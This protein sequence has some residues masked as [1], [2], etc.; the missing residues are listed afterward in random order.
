VAVFAESNTGEPGA[1]I[2]RMPGS[3]GGRR[4]RV[5]TRGYLAGGLPCGSS[6]STADVHGRSGGCVGEYRRSGG[7]PLRAERRVLKIQTTLYQEICQPTWDLRRARCG[8]SRTAGSGSGP[9]K[10]AGRKT[11]TAPQTDFTTG[12]GPIELCGSSHPSQITPPRTL[13]TDGSSA[14]PSWAACS[15]NTKAQPKTAAQRQ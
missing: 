2:S 12:D 4:K 1:V 8:E 14:D 13:P 15:T 7:R 10:R 11:G 3:V 9:G 6:R 5:R